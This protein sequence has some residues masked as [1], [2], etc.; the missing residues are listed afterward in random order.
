MLELRPSFIS[1]HSQGY[2]DS[3]HPR[4]FLSRPSLKNTMKLFYCGRVLSQRT[5]SLK[6][7]IA[8]KFYSVQHWILDLETN[9]LFVR[10]KIIL[11]FLPSKQLVGF[12]PHHLFGRF[13]AMAHHRGFN[14]AA[15]SRWLNAIAQQSWAQ[16]PDPWTLVLHH[17]PFGSMPWFGSLLARS[18][19]HMAQVMI[20]SHGTT[21]NPSHGLT[22][23]GDQLIRPAYSASE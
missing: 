5:Q 20:R 22:M 15:Y 13:N 17:G 6:F 3:L 10:E 1:I 12:V 16:Q 18:M 4:N 9:S 2:W 7:S 14:V 21:V 19:D 23:Q 8:L 11:T